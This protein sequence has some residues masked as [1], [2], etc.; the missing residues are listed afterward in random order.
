MCP[1]VG[2]AFAQ[3][4]GHLKGPPNVPARHNIGVGIVVYML[5]I[6]IR[7]DNTTDVA[8]AI[9]FRLGTARPEPPRLE[10]NLG[11]CLEEEVYILSC[12]PVLP[13]RICDVCGN[14][15]F[16]LPAKD[17]DDPAVGT[18]N[19]LRRRLH[20]SVRRLPGVHG[21]APSHLGRLLPRAVDRPEAIHEQRAGRFRPGEDVE[22]QQIYFRVP[23]DMPVIVVAGEPACSD[24]NALIGR[25]GRTGE[26][27][28]S[29]TQRLLSGRIA[30][31][32]D[33][34]GTPPI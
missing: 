18:N 7:S 32:L 9:P 3:H 30:S 22:R 11:P 5:V 27:V 23:E 28:D 10:E 25:I 26:V 8:V 15:L 14:V 33:I 2:P 6:L 19:L 16:L 12:L 17:I 4:R 13:D 24:G 31:D 29:E 34:A 1:A 21:A 20:T